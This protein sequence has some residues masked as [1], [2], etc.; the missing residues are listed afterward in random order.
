LRAEGPYITYEMIRRMKEKVRNSLGGE[1]E[2][3]YSAWICD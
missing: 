1:E 3:D 2:M